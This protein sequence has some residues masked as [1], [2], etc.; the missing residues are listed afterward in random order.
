MH[1]A[2]KQSIT[3]QLRLDNIVFQCGS[4]EQ[5]FSNNTLHGK[6]NDNDDDHK[7]TLG[8]SLT[9]YILLEE[10]QKNRRQCK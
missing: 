1:G 2:I 4:T 10:S 7:F 5:S 9:G 3:Q 6:G 8:S